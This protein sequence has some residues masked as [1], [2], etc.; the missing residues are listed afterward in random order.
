MLRFITHLI[1]Y[2]LLGSLLLVIGF[3]L[4]MLYEETPPVREYIPQAE[5]VSLQD[6]ETVTDAFLMACALK[7]YDSAAWL[8]A[9]SWA[10]EIGDIERLCLSVSAPPITE[11]R[12]LGTQQQTNQTAFIEWVWFD[13][14]DTAMVTYFLLEQFGGIGWQIV[15]VTSAN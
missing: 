1:G 13:A 11:D 15:G 2:L 4:G 8:V 12:F 5:M 6:P 10:A 3:A 9:P 14:N 7:E